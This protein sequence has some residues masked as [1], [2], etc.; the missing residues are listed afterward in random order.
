[1]GKMRVE[2]KNWKDEE[3]ICEQL[4]NTKLY[5]IEFNSTDKPPMK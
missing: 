1:M 5:L 4:L 3:N 2:G